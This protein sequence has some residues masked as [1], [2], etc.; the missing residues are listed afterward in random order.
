MNRIVSHKIRISHRKIIV[1]NFGE[2]Y[3]KQGKNVEKFI[4]MQQ[5][6]NGAYI[7]KR[8]I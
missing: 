3:Q 2:N 5:K 4:Y 6:K 1:N 7:Q 8:K